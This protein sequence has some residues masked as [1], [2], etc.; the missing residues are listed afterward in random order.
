MVVKAYQDEMKNLL[1][2]PKG[3][4]GCS[5]LGAGGFPTKML[6][7]FLFSDHEKGVKFLKECGLLKREMFCP[8]CGSNMSI[9][10]SE[11]VIDEYRW[12]CGK[13]KRGE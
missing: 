7:G 4:F 3:S 1:F 8:K 12:R 6:F 13:G 5:V 10:R 11:S 9:W 2:V